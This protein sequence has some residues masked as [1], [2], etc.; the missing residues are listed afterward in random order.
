MMM[1]L[2]IGLMAL[3]TFYNRYAFFSPQ[4]KFS[5]GPRLQSLLSYTA[6]AVL[7]ALWV[8]IVFVSE[9]PDMEAKQLNWQLDNPYFCA[10]LIT[11]AISAFVRKPLITVALGVLV[12][13][14]WSRL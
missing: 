2:M 5:I 4:L 1:W 11:V 6:P 10:G 12:F 9:H 3:V 14:G 8:P 13:A 7:T